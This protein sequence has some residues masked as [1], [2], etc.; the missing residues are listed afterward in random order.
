MHKFFL[1]SFAPMA[2]SH[3]THCVQHKRL[4]HPH[5][6]TTI[7]KDDGCCFSQGHAIILRRYACCHSL[8]C[9]IR[10]EVWATDM[11]E[12]LVRVHAARE[13]RHSSGLM[14]LS[15]LSPGTATVVI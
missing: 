8:Q 15:P 3:S 12:A 1:A 14:T 6:N 5:A 4:L 10:E 13:A 2:T 11:V 9:F 7:R